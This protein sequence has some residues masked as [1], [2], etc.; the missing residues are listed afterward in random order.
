[1]QIKCCKKCLSQKDCYTA[2][3]RRILT[4]MQALISNSNLDLTN[5]TAESLQQ[6]R[7][8]FEEFEC[9]KKRLREESGSSDTETDILI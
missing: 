3:T 4:G 8:E 1:M 2:K 5:E 9:K 6:L 7:A